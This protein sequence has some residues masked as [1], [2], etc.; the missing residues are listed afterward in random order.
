MTN[1]FTYADLDRLQNAVTDLLVDENPFLK[2]LSDPD[3]YLFKNMKEV[4]SFLEA[5]ASIAY[6]KE[7]AQA[8]AD[9]AA[10]FDFRAVRVAPNVPAWDIMMS[11][12]GGEERNVGLLSDFPMEASYVCTLRAD[13]ANQEVELRHKSRSDMFAAIREAMVERSDNLE[14]YESDLGSAEY[15]AQAEIDYYRHLEDLAEQRGSTCPVE[16]GIAAPF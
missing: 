10:R 9:H 16:N 12:D 5:A 6:E 7:K 3:S 14:H 11:Y 4:A 1:Q 8:D 2:E 13:D 15:E